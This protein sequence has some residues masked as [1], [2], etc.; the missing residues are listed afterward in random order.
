MIAFLVPTPENVLDKKGRASGWRNVPIKDVHEKRKFR[1]MATHLKDKGAS[2]I[3]CS[4][5][6]EEA[7]NILGAELNLPVKREWFMR[8]FNFGKHH[9]AQ[10]DKAETILGEL[11]EKWKAN[12]DIPMR[13]GDSLSSYKKRFIEG[14]K[15]FLESDGTAIV[16]TDPR[17][18]QVIV[19]NF[20]PHALITNGNAIKR[21]SI[22]KVAK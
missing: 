18:I 12:P 14:F 19:G 17:T 8:R 22:F 13:G 16:V 1:R 21:T 3:V 10:L 2:K 7:A 5:L 6:D 4:D 9:A 11:E 20:E 15:K